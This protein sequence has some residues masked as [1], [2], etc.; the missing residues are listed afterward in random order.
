MGTRIVG[1][2]ENCS[3]EFGTDLYHK[4]CQLNQSTPADSETATTKAPTT[5]LV[6][7]S[8]YTEKDYVCDQY[9]E[10]N[11]AAMVSVF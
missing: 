6:N 3:K 5:S 4:F 1:S 2:V 9:F 8:L 7:E 10:D 11:P